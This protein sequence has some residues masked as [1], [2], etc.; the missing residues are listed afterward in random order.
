MSRT[1]TY[2]HKRP[3]T[4]IGKNILNLVV[5]STCSNGRIASGHKMLQ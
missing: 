1:V 5:D 4:G 2:S 3:N